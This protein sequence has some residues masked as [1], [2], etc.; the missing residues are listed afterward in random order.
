MQ[1]LV[2]LGKHDCR[3]SPLHGN[4]G[5]MYLSQR[6]NDGLPSSGIEPIVDNLADATLFSEPL[7]YTAASWYISLKCLSQGYTARHASVGIEPST[8]LLQLLVG[9]NKLSYTVAF[10]VGRFQNISGKISQ[11]FCEKMM[12]L[13]Y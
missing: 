5:K 3:C 9:A 6:H 12:F 11:Y 13:V 8:L 7:S 2:R 1:P 10:A 4:I